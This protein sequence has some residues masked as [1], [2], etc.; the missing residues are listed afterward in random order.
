LLCER[1]ATNTAKVYVD[2][3]Y[4]TTIRAL[5][6]SLTYPSYSNLIFGS[7]CAGGGAKNTGQW[8]NVT[9]RTLPKR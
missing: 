8:A 9:F 2:G 1:P 7:G 4:Q 3:I 6:G 5:T